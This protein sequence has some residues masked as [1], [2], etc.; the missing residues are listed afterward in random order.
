L[1][2]LL[3]S[4]IIYSVKIPLL[5]K[6][7]KRLNFKIP[8]DFAN[9]IV[10]L[11]FEVI[12]YEGYAYNDMQTVTIL[13][14]DKVA[15]EIILDWPSRYIVNKGDQLTITWKVNDV[16][17]IRSINFYIDWNPIK[18]GLKER[19]FKYTIDTLNYNPWKHLLKVEAYDTNFNVG[20]VEYDL[21]IK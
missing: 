10:T 6:W 18:L 4:K 9:K 20:F 8:K 17:W 21:I 19:N 12:D 7:I 5:N 13:S 3:N 16:S 11:K 15:P 2:I 1:N 14:S